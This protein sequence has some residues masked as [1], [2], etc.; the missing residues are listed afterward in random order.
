MGYLHFER[1]SSAI[2]EAYQKLENT[3]TV[4]LSAQ[5]GP[6]WHDIR[7][8]LVKLDA[9][10]P[11]QVTYV[12]REA[13]TITENISVG[14]FYYILHF[15]EFGIYFPTKVKAIIDDIKQK[16]IKLNPFLTGERYALVCDDQDRTQHYINSVVDPWD[17]DLES[18]ERLALNNPLKVMKLRKES[19]GYYKEHTGK[20]GCVRTG[21]G[22]N[23]SH[24]DPDHSYMGKNKPHM[25]VDLLAFEGTNI[26]SS[27]NGTAYLY[28]K[29]ISGYGKVISVKGK[30]LN[31]VTQKEED[32]YVL[33]A[34]LKEISVENGDTVKVGDVIG[35]T[36]RSGN[37]SDMYKAE[38]HLHLEILTEKWPSSKKG[39]N[40]RKPPLDYFSVIN[41]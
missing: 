10:R 32:V 35:K 41:P 7:I 23:C 29:E 20:F 39:F 37:A 11:M 17:Y 5:D 34:H 8:N 12:A 2:E 14:K 4:F 6:I 24:P 40:S 31:L 25:G 18:E 1:L 16:E 27:V 3:E 22:R 13:K 26:Y 19:N 30:L 33:Y 28:E 21:N 15:A 9:R 38:E 36:G